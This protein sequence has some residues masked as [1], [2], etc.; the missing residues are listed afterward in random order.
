MTMQVGMVGTDGVLIASDTQWNNTP[1]KGPGENAY[2]PR[3]PFNAQKIIV[4]HEKG[5][6]ISQARVMETARLVATRI[7]SRLKDEDLDY[8]CDSIRAIGTTVLDDVE[9]FA[10]RDAHCLI[11]IAL[12][13]PKLYLFYFGDVDGKLGPI[14]QKMES[15]KAAGDHVNAAIFWK[16]RYYKR[17]PIRKLVPLAAH[18][19]DSASQLNRGSISG[20]EI[21]LCDASGLHRVDEESIRKLEAKANR[22]D[23]HI[24]SLFTKYKQDFTFAEKDA[25]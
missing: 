20:L 21:V 22:W 11:A 9:D 15:S 19:I 17:R 16:E 13:S 12:P 8:P 23:K 24:G 3:E 5:I 18:L 6:A 4:S 1:T 25:G 14:C 10:K 7:I 2:L